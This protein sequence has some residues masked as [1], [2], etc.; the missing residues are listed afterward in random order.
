MQHILVVDDEQSMLEFLEYLLKKE[1]YQVTSRGSG[2]EA[3]QLVEDGTPFDLVISDLQMPGMD[4]LEFLKRSREVEAELPFIF[5]TAYASSDTAI[6]ALK[7]GAFDYVT[8]P[9]QVEELKHLVNNVLETVD[10]KRKVKVYE[11]GKHA[12]GYEES[13]QSGQLVGISRPMLE[14]YKLIGTIAQTDSTVLISGESGTGKELVARAVHAA[15]PRRGG[16]FVSVNCGALTETLLESELFGY[17]KGS[18]TG[19]VSDKKGL[20]ETADK[21]TLFL[22]EIGEMSSAMQVRLLRAL[23]EKKVRRVGGVSEIPVDARVIAATNRNMEEEI[24]AGDFR[25]DLYYRLAVI[26]MHIPPLREREADILTLVRHFMKRCNEKLN[27]NILGIT[28]EGL[29]C[30]ESYSWPG[31]VRELENVIERA[32]A[33]ESSEYIQKE[34]LPEKI[35]LGSTSPS[36]LLPSFV[37]QEGFDLQEYLTKVETQAIRRALDLAGGNQ[38]VAAEILRLSYRSFRHRV[39]RLGVKSKASP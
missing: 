33:L 11:K 30:L 37:E 28:E 18:F 39:E 27:R 32:T 4:G 13:A 2:K 35:R 23:Q 21:G 26:P 12:D 1:G 20:F 10:L 34:R 8:K 31:N 19:A 24:E 3:L 5:I 17:M 16:A 7:M 6:E 22:D 14:V 9:F 38:K 15:S 36:V 29:A 25:E